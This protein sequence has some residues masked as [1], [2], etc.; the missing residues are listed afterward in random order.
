MGTIRSQRVD[1]EQSTHSTL[2]DGSNNEDRIKRM[3][4][5]RSSRD[6]QEKMKKV[7]DNLIPI[8]PKT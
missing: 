8:D 6:D 3:E 1:D 2:M 4:S 7:T 5:I